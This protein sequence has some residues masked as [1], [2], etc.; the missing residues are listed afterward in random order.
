MTDNWRLY[1]AR[2]IEII[3]GMVFIVAGGLKAWE[4]LDFIRQIGDYQILTA[5]GLIKLI[6]WVMIVAEIA[7]GTALIVGYRRRW[8]VLIAAIMLF[9]FLITLGWAWY[10]GSTEDCGCFGSWVKRTPAEAFTEDLAMLAAIGLAWWLHR[11][12]HGGFSRWRPATV[13]LSVLIGL[14][15]TVY[16][17]NSARQSDD[18]LQ[19]LKSVATQPDL[20]AGIEVSGLPLSVNKGRRI[21]A[22]IDTGCEHCQ[23]SVPELNRLH[24]ELEPLGVPLVALCSNSPE[25]ISSFIAR[26]KAEFPLG[27][28]SF[29]N[30][31]K[32]F[33]R[34]QP[35]RLLLVNDGGLLKIWDGQVPTLTEAQTF[36]E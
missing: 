24:R 36:I 10:S 30:F 32:L 27:R 18:P 11:H 17:S 35:P 9:G 25:D 7:L 13:A 29:D 28:V 5:P 2:T 34:G 15:V 12:E 1:L 6:A 22:L 21:I 19:R 8:S 14:S 4:P 20:F 16:A 31:R 26:F 23:A 33:E 3:I